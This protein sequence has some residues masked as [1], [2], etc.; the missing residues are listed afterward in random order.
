MPDPVPPTEI[1]LEFADGD[2][3]FALRIPQLAELQEK[4]KA[5][6]FTIY[7]RV[8]KGRYV[9]EGE[10]VGLAHEADAYSHDLYETIRLGLIGGGRG[11]VDGQAVKVGPQEARR[12]MERYV[13][14]APLREAWSIAAAILSAKIEGYAPPKKAEPAQEPAKPGRKP[15]TDSTSRT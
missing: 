6:I 12:L 5:G 7:G 9:F 4:C 8:L 14:P 11:L 10:I 3:L 2:Y 15:K 13:H 1:E